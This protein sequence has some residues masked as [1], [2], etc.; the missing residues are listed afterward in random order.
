MES[1]LDQMVNVIAKEECEQRSPNWITSVI[2]PALYHR[3]VSS[4]EKALI[5]SKKT[6]ECY[7]TTA[8]N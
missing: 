1:Q 6:F 8:G 3:E 7:S 5:K 4:T 2:R